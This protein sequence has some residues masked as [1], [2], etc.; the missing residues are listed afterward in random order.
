MCR[1]LPLTVTW[2][3]CTRD[4]IV[5]MPLLSSHYIIVTPRLHWLHPIGCISCIGCIGCIGTSGITSM[6]ELSVEMVQVRLKLSHTSV[7]STP[8]ANQSDAQNYKAWVGRLSDCI[9]WFS[10]VNYS[11]VC[12][13]KASANSR[14]NLYYS[15]KKEVRNSVE[16]SVRL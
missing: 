11:V 5:L 7:L 14:E 2:N 4:W 3:S 10:C 13:C 16:N 6:I 8:K 1:S 15:I 12:K 9:D